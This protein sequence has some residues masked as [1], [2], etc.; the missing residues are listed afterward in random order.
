MP[1]AWHHTGC[2][3]SGVLWA[4]RNRNVLL[5]QSDDQTDNV[6]EEAIKNGV[7]GG[8]REQSIQGA[9]KTVK[10]GDGSMTCYPLGPFYSET[11]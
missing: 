2:Q 11:S 5:V 1:R 9:E 3:P 6:K 10:D 8:T 4:S 7:G